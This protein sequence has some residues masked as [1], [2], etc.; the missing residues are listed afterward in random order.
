MLNLLPLVR[1]AAEQAQTRFVKKTQQI[2]AVQEQFL[3][4]LLRA[5]SGTVL[6]QEYHLHDI[7]TIEQFQQRVP[8][9]PYSGYSSYI[10][11]IAA[12]EPNVL[13]P[14]PVVY[15]NKTSGSTGKYKLIPVTRRFQNSMGWANLTSIGFLSQAL[16]SRGSRFGRGM[17]INQ[18]IEPEVTTGGIEYGCAGPGVLRMGAGLYQQLFV[19]PFAALKP[20][21]TLTRTYLCLLF[22]LKNSPVGLAGNFPM[23][24]LQTCKYLEDHA[25]SLIH[26]LETGTLAAWLQLDPALRQSLTAQ[27]RPAPKQ[28]QRLRE[29]LRSEGRL[30]PRTAWPTLAF[31]GTAR[32]GTTDFY[33]ERFPEYFGD[34]PGFGFLFTTAEGTF[35]IYPDLNTNGSVL[36]IETGFFEFIPMAEWEAEQPKT[37]LAHEVEAGQLY[38]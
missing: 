26:D 18:A 24:I 1:L 2:A 31:Y 13:T 10:E 19:H 34:T 25:E 30:T 21:D 4:R 6:G 12:G 8:I 28:A 22:A 7:R 17:V 36:A 9:L 14:D 3:W 11:R 32:G 15:L 29:I 16:R 20:R 33:L 37:L 23:V 27:L 5:Y 38:R 35:S